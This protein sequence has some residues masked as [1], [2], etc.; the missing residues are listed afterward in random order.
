M[1]PLRVRNLSLMEHDEDGRMFDFDVQ[2]GEVLVILGGNGSGKS[3]LLACLAGQRTSDFA[4][5]KVLGESLFARR[6][7]PSAQSHLGVVFQ[8]PGLLRTLSVFDNVALP[9]LEDSLSLTG[10][11]AEFVTLRLGLVGCGHLAEQQPEVLGEGDRR[12][13]ALA[14]ALSGSTRILLADEPAAA[15]SFDKR[16]RIG[17]LIATLVRRGALDCAVIFTQDV[18]F[19][20]AVGTRFFFLKDPDPETGAL[21]GI[22]EERTAANLLTDPAPSEVAVFMARRIK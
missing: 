21:G 16:D 7:R 20:I 9:F 22:R 18:E 2:R 12:C 4:E 8:H 19:A 10:E 15:L 17:E 6:T 14:R 11:L 1:P 5:V 3:L 13:V